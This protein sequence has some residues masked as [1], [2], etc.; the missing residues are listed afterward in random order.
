[1][2]Y[3]Y[4][5]FDPIGP[6]QPLMHVIQEVMAERAVTS[7]GPGFSKVDGLRLATA[8]HL[9]VEQ[10]ANVLV[11]LIVATIRKIMYPP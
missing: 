4:T 1:M 11:G 2:L 9:T 3:W 5:G 10:D 7:K 6:H 8:L